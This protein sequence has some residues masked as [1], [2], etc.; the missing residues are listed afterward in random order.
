MS[1]PRPGNFVIPRAHARGLPIGHLE[2]ALSVVSISRLAVFLWRHK[3]LT[4]GDHQHDLRM[5]RSNRLAAGLLPLGEYCARLARDCC[6]R[7]MSA[8]DADIIG[9]ASPSRGRAAA[10]YRKRCFLRIERESAFSARRL[11]LNTASW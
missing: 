7:V 9:A 11:C 8:G 10:D 6:R 2:T 5:R 4:L 3:P 1:R